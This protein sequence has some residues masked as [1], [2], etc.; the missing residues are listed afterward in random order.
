MLYH[1]WDANKNSA[2]LSAIII[3]GAL[4][5]PE[6]IAGMTEQSAKRNFSTPEHVVEYL[7]QIDYQTP[8]DKYQAKPF[9]QQARLTET[10]QKCRE[11]DGHL[12]VAYP[13]RA[14][15]PSR[16]H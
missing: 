10:F 14:R 6:V 16:L 3:V 8:Y 15:Y 13:Y 2:H 7:Q 1:E 4:V 5:L 12:G 9:R 11:P